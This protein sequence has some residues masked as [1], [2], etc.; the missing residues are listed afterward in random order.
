MGVDEPRIGSLFSGYGGL[1]LAVQRVV[2]GTVVW[3]SDIDPGANQ[4]LAHLHAD[5]PNLGDV[6]RI[7]W[8]LVDASFPG[9]EGLGR[10]DVL[11]MGFPCQDV[12][13][14]G[15]RAGL[16]KGTNRS[17]LWGEGLRAIVALQPR[18]VVVENV[19]GLLSARTR[20]A[21]DG[22][23][24]G[25]QPGGTG[26]GLEPCPDCLGEAEARSYDM[27][28]LGAV[29]ADLASVGYDAQWVGL[30]A[31][32]VGACH[33]RFRVF[34]LAGPAGATD[35]GEWIA[36]A[37]RHGA[38]TA[39]DAGRL[40]HRDHGAPAHTNGLELERGMEW[41]SG[42]AQPADG[43]GRSPAPAGPSSN[44]GTREALKLLKTPTSNL[45]SNGGSQHPDKRREGGH[46]PTLADEVEHL[47]PCP[48]QPRFLPTPTTRDHKGRNQRD[49]DSCLPGAIDRM[50]GGVHFDGPL[51]PT[52]SV[53]DMGARKTVSEWDAWV[54][55]QKEKGIN[56]NGHG[57]SLAIE[58]L[59]MLPTP[60]ASD[61][62]KG[63]P[64]QRGS[65]GDLALPAV[66][67]SL[68]EP[69]GDDAPHRL[70]EPRPDVF[71]PYA[72]AVAR[73]ETALGRT[74]PAPTEPT[75]TGYR[76]SPAFVEWMMM[77]PAG[78]V[79]GVPGLTR[80][81]MLKALGNGVV[82]H[83]GAAAFHHLLRV[84]AMPAPA[85]SDVR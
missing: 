56:G 75:R 38:D 19:R 23:E 51:L 62:P 63:G 27:R 18:W 82:P 40:G 34:L 47:L 6:S 35:T 33:H 32:D 61:G 43:G 79:T 4:V 25:G 71:G 50:P 7:D 17:G 58:A 81:A 15:L 49:D 21:N 8:E 69:C 3:V 65:R 55:R 76:L 74:A 64:N 83:Q 1:D 60:R 67:A 68:P 46:G 77:L 37:E 52:P 2:G 26:G 70:G 59:R 84:A 28:A 31:A 48:D 5:I 66:A 12:S 20:K 44:H 11:T 29:L 24:E 72:A 16:L 57:R 13:V 73:A 30:E 45:G 14:A 22:E 53:V 9:H 10:I 41:Q 36:R 39:G 54:A 85:D 80:T 78:H 42:C